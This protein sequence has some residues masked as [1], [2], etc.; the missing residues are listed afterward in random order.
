MRARS[1][2]TGCDLVKLREHVPECI[3]EYLRTDYLDTG[4][5]EQLAYSGEEDRRINTS[6]TTKLAEAVSQR[7]AYLVD[8]GAG[9]GI[10]GHAST[11][12]G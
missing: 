3:S 11:L 1:C 8:G 6:R 5:E 7:I 2:G 4:V 10:G 12:A 9:F